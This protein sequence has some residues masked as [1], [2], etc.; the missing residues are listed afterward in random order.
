MDFYLGDEY[1][2]VINKITCQKVC[3]CVLLR[4]KS[5]EYLKLYA[6]VKKRWKIEHTE[7]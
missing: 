5:C 1:E 3:V 7:P 4:K 2:L 6:L